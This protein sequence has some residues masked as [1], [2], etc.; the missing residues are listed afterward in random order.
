MIL[1][2]LCILNVYRYR[3]NI[4]TMIKAI[5]F[6]YC[7]LVS[8]CIT[9]ALD[10]N[11]YKSIKVDEDDRKWTFMFVPQVVPERR[12]DVCYVAMI[13]GTIIVSVSI[14]NQM[15]DILISLQTNNFEE[16]LNIN[17]IPS[18]V[19]CS[20]DNSSGVEVDDFLCALNSESKIYVYVRVIIFTLHEDNKTLNF[21]I[22]QIELNSKVYMDLAIN[23]SSNALDVLKPLF[24]SCKRMSPVFSNHSQINNAVC[25]EM[26]GMYV[27]EGL[28]CFNE[29]KRSSICQNDI[30]SLNQNVVV[31]I[32]STISSSKDIYKCEVCGKESST[33]GNL[34]SHVETHSNKIRSFPCMY[35]GCFSSFRQQ[36][37]LNSHMKYHDDEVC[38]PCKECGK[39]HISRFSLQRH[40]VVHTGEMLFKCDLCGKSFPREFSMIRHVKIRHTKEKDFHCKKCG[41]GFALNAKLLRHMKSQHKNEEAN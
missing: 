4:L 8:L 36:R 7:L 19:L 1:K 5:L 22:E 15:N 3:L 11:I 38:Y 31:S 23:S 20:M 29:N 34:K 35:D 27:D 28:D 13:D 37:Y 39:K 24:A 14:I 32:D 41:R 26:P 10:N 16:D 33:K 40:M 30:D 18:F 17:N 6:F 2:L 25:S 21:K 12:E 9:A